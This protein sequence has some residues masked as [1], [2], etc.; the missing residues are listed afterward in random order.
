[1]RQGYGVKCDIWSMGVIL[2]IML[3]GFPPFYNENL[4]KLF[5]HIMKKPHDFPSPEW[6]P[7]SPEAKDLL[8]KMMT[9]DP[10][11][12]LSASDCLAHPWVGEDNAKTPLDA[13]A[14]KLRHFMRRRELRKGIEAVQALKKMEH[15]LH[16][17]H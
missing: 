12:R 10:H 9:K 8:N 5:E 13:S 15:L 7:I 4:P 6:D 17:V 3:C 2:Y 11:K 16:S 14:E 1:M